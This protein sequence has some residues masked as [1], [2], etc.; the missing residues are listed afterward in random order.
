MHWADKAAKQI[1]DSGNY[2]PYWVDDMKTPS[3]YSHIGSLK[4]PLIHS[5]IYRA[6]KDLGQEVKYTFIFNDFDP[7]DEFPPEFKEQLSNYAGFPLKKIPSPVKGFD[8]LADLLANDL[9]KVMIELGVEAEFLS[10]W[11]MYKKGDFDEVIKIALD[12]ADKIQDIYQKVSGSDK[13]QKGWL[14]FQPICE[15]CGRIGTTRTHAWDGC[16]VSYRCEEDMVSWAKGCGYEGKVTPFGGSGKLPW[17]VDWPA[18]W[19]VL[20]ITIEGAGKDHASAGGS[21]DIAMELCDKVFDFPKPFKMPYEFILIGGKKMSSSKGLGL[22]A[23]DVTKILPPELVRFLF[24]RTDLRQQIEFDPQKESTISDLFDE[25]DRC[26]MAFQ[27]GE[28]VKLIKTFLFSQI[29]NIPERKLTFLP[30]FRDVVN[31]I[32]LAEKDLIKKFSEIKGGS[33]NNLEREILEERIKYAKYW[34]ENI[35]PEESKLQM[36]KEVPQGVSDL[37]SQQ[38]K[39]LSQVIGVVTKEKDAQKLQSTLYD[40]AKESGIPVKDA[41]AAIYISFIGKEHG[42]R[43]AQFL[44]QYPQKEVLKRLQEVVK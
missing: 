22:K 1:V 31:Y 37:T 14:P 41:F 3:G 12:N 2:K 10:S 9:K 17:R 39:F 18:H 4:G 42:P 11:E 21:Y 30:R 20:G 26:Y 43:A 25:Y 38:K 6:L 27:K 35:A 28:D 32:Q 29:K 36:L 7:A 5:V 16:E 34:L 23:H 15:K 19:R 8:S 40:L 13:R 24:T 44:L 33:L